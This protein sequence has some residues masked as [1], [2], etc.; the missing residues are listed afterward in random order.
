MKMFN[1][2]ICFCVQQYSVC[3]KNNFQ[4]N[5]QN[6]FQK[7]FPKQKKTIMDDTIMD[8]TVMDFVYKDEPTIPPMWAF[9]AKV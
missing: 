6:D 2:C 5:F 1:F 3:S 9:I 4:N 8:D 7:Q